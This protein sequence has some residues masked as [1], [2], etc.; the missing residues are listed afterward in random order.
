MRCPTEALFSVPTE[1]LIK[2]QRD[3]L[4]VSPVSS[5]KNVSRKA[6]AGKAPAKKRSPVTVAKSK[7]NPTAKPKYKGKG[8][9]K[10]TAEEIEDD[11]DGYMS[12]YIDDEEEEVQTILMSHNPPSSDGFQFP[13]YLVYNGSESGRASQHDSSH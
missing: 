12:L 4:V 6:A 2:Y 13:D 8:K 1:E 7:A 5:P 10:A 11:S 3:A 9:A